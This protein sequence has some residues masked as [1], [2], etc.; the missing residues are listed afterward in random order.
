M[1]LED[2]LSLFLAFRR[3]DIPTKKKTFTYYDG[4]DGLLEHLRGM[5]DQF[6]GKK[7]GICLSA[8]IDSG[9]VASIFRP[10][11]AYTLVYHG[12][13]GEFVNSELHLNGA[14]HVPV[15]VTKVTYF[16]AAREAIRLLQ[17]PIPP[18]SPLFY[19][20]AQRAK[21]DGCD[22]LLTGL[23][24]EG[25]GEMSHFYA[26]R[27]RAEFINRLFRM[28]VDPKSVL[29]NPSNI[30]WVFD[31]YCTDGVI[32][33][34]RFLSEI[35]TGGATSTNEGAIDLAG[36]QAFSPFKS[37][38]F[39]GKYKP[40][41]IAK[42][43]IKPHLSEAYNREY[44]VAPPKKKALAAPYRK[45]MAGWRHSREEFLTR[46]HGRVALPGKR[47]FLVW[48]IEQYLN[49]FGGFNAS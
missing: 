42:G 7:V 47:R 34:Q 3:W 26:H 12:N 48:A 18:H 22:V 20:M 40:Y 45:W 2:K 10:S 30:D 16:N 21:R 36:V 44:G 28:T 4:T 39:S 29:K 23:G 24:A 1:Q 43:M 5:K 25:N 17:E 6:Q 15:L 37:L 35:G 33:V 41:L 14:S 19:L 9:L 27:K 8:G 49:K 46:L 31:S 38:R 32:D 13:D 11:M